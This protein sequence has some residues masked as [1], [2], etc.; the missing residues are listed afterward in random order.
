MATLSRLLRVGSL[1]NH[2]VRN[3]HTGEMFFYE[4]SEW[5]REHKP[6]AIGFVLDNHIAP[7]PPLPDDMLS[8]PRRLRVWRQ[9]TLD[10]GSA[11]HDEW[12][13]VVVRGCVHLR[14]AIQRNAR[15]CKRI[16]YALQA[17]YGALLLHWL[18]GS[19]TC[20]PPGALEH[21]PQRLLASFTHISHY[22][23]LVLSD[24]DGDGDGGNDTAEK[25]FNHGTFGELAQLLLLR[26]AQCRRIS[27]VA[28]SERF[29]GEGFLSD[30]EEVCKCEPCVEPSH[31]DALSL[32]HALALEPSTLPME[33][34]DSD[35]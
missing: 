14:R 29:F 3:K 19:R 31:R 5:A 9:D 8:I 16:G 4:Q 22:C 32:Q 7:P 24:G 13:G 35:A 30:L 21:A 33:S 34:S 23:V 17:H 10:G 26:S 27:Y 11:G 25:R 18:D 28:L 1:Y 15:L 2:A 12:T 6:A 20:I